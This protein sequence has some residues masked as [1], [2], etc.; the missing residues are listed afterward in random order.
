MTY[1]HTHTCT[2][3]S[4]YLPKKWPP[5][6]LYTK[7]PKNTIMHTAVKYKELLKRIEVK[8]ASPIWKTPCFFTLANACK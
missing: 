3:L 8:T 1:T 6:D 7:L 5:V 4:F 2:R